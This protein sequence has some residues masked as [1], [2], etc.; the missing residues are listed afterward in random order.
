[1][2]LNK[3]MKTNTITTTPYSDQKPGTSGLRK[4]VTVFQQPHYLENFVQ[5]IFDS[6]ED[7]SGQTLVVGGDR[8]VTSTLEYQYYLNQKWRAAVF[9]DAGDAF[10]D[11]EFETN[12]GAGFGIHGTTHLGAGLA[13]P[14]GQ[15]HGVPAARGDPGDVALRIARDARDLRNARYGEVFEP[16]SELHPRRGELVDGQ[17]SE[18]VADLGAVEGDPDHA[19]V[20]CSVVGDVGEVEP[21]NGFPHGWVE[22]LRYHDPIL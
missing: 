9:V 8:L 14:G 16:M 11:G 1:M 10:D 5:S 12:V 22:D 21:R 17:G 15:D 6:L 7:F 20:A 4:K 13:A 2:T 3:Q 18:G 19:G